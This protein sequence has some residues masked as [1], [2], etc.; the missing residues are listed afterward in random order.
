ML[1]I[2]RKAWHGPV[3]ASRPAF[4]AGF[5]KERANED[6]AYRCPCWHEF[7]QNARDGARRPARA[8]QGARRP[9]LHWTTYGRGVAISVRFIIAAFA[10]ANNSLHKPRFTKHA[11]QHSTKQL[12]AQVM[13]FQPM[14]VEDKATNP[15]I[16]HC[17]GGIGVSQTC[18]ERRVTLQ[19][20]AGSASRW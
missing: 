18:S 8:V 4:R 16:Q 3:M 19:A 14:S 9:S 6:T 7:P 1:Y 5:T 12:P 2:G 11:H 10:K 20:W 13:Q 15:P 17:V